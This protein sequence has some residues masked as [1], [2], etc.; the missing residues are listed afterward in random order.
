[1]I[2]RRD[3]RWRTTYGATGE[4]R[5]PSDDGAPSHGGACACGCG[6]PVS[7]PNA[8]FASS[9]CESLNHAAREKARGRLAELKAVLRMA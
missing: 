4:H 7:S 6:E 1:M 5:L 8:T 2:R 9:K 3:F